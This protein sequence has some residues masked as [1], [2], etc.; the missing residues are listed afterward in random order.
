M[1][2]VAADLHLCIGMDRRDRYLRIVGRASQ[3][4]Y[5]L[6]GVPCQGLSPEYLHEL[7]EACNESR[8]DFASRADLKPHTPEELLG[9]LRKLRRKYEVIAV[10]CDSKKVA[11]QAAKDRRVDLLNFPQPDY[12]R[13]SFDEAEAELASNC[14]ASLEIDIKP[15]LTSEGPARVRLLSDVRRE[16]ATAQQFGV[17]VVISSGASDEMLMRKPRELAA[18]ASLFS[19]TADQAVKA[20]SHNPNA[21]VK[22]NREKLDSGFIAPGIR[23]VKKGKNL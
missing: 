11:R 8:V 13:C 6:I 22:R 20:M 15:L 5:N 19:L 12:H 4:G 10:M 7:R 14:L 17:P 2:P 23:I 1:K 16:L 21:I 3:L 18:L 9:L